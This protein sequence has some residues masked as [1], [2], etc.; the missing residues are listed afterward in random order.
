MAANVLENPP[1]TLNCGIWV[2][3][4]VYREQLEVVVWLFGDQSKDVCECATSI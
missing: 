2:V 3:A 4:R 1:D